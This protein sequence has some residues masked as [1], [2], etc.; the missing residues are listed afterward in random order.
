MGKRKVEISKEP[1]AP[2]TIGKLNTHKFGWILV[3][4]VFALFVGIIYYLPEL[5]KVYNNGS[6][7][8]EPIM[9]IL[10]DLNI[11]PKN[12]SSKPVINETNDFLI[13]GVDSTYEIEG[14]YFSEIN[15]D[16][17]TISFVINNNTN[18]EIDIKSLNIFFEVYN[19]D[20]LING[21][22]IDKLLQPGEKQTIEYMTNKFV[23]KFKIYTKENTEENETTSDMIELS[24][25][26]YSRTINYE[27]S[28]EGLVSL[29]DKDHFEL[30]DPDYNYYYDMYKNIENNGFVNINLN[31]DDLGFEYELKI[32]YN[33]GEINLNDGA[34]FKKGAS[35]DEIKTYMEEYSYT[36]K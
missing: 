31:E 6:F 11:I 28:N 35:L 16:N 4:L 19:N 29:T 33:K 2:T 32:D 27:L 18:N 22:Q 21:Y 23:N 13:F 15:Y 20:M 7:N 10:A 17:E 12:S 9:N 14:I 36:C 25:T 3:I 34:Y 1:L 26:S 24:C 8:M 5:S 30:N